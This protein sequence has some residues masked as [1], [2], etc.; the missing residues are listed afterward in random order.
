[1]YLNPY[2]SSAEW[3]ATER[4]PGLSRL[5][6]CIAI[7]VSCILGIAWHFVAI[8]IMGDGSF[9]SGA[10]WM[11]AGIFAGLCCGAF[12][13]WS[14]QQNSERESFF[15]VAITYYLGMAAY[16]FGILVIENVVLTIAARSANINFHDNLKI[17]FWFFALGTFP[18]GFLLLPLSF[19]S[20]VVVW[21]SYTARLKHGG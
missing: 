3:P 16:W 15:H 14:R 9:S 13:I 10:R 6:L 4:R 12:T 20:R 8:T 19:L 18:F 21:Y 1:M 2:E 7:V 17:I 5:R 11:G